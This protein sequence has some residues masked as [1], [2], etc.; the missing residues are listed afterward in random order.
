[1][2]GRVVPAVL[3]QVAL[4]SGRLDLLRDIDAPRS[5]KVVKFSLE[6]VVRLLAHPGDAVVARL[7]HGHSLVLRRTCSPR[8]H[9][10][11]SGVISQANEGPRLMSSSQM[12]APGQLARNG[13]CRTAERVFR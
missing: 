10:R 7:S 13:E 3:L 12:G 9:G 8:D 1:V 11:S 5:R 2:L 6:P 4:V